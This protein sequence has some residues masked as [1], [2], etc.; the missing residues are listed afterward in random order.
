MVKNVYA[1][2]FVL[3][4]VTMIL[5]FA[6][7]FLGMNVDYFNNS[8]LL[9]AFLLPAVYVAGAYL[10]VNSAKKMGEP[11]GFQAVFGRSFK[12]MFVG[13]FLSILTMFLFLNFVDKGAKDLLNFQ[14]IER[15]KTELTNEYEK[16]KSTMVKDEEKA[17]LEKNY[18]NRLK[19]FSPEMIKDKDM[20]SFRQFTYYFGAIMV[21][22][23]I[24]SVFFASFFRSR[25]EE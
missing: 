13:G 7:Y 14:Y 16:A 18:Q 5:F 6:M 19:S 25:L 15:Q 21:F 8:V 1:V 11:M 12:P 20:F 10:S 2:G 3:F 22:Y 23:V 4:I 24:L 17:E 9:N